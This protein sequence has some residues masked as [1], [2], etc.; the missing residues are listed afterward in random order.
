MNTENFEVNNTLKKLKS[1]ICDTK[2]NTVLMLVSIAVAILTLAV[3]FTIGPVVGYNVD[4][5]ISIPATSGS[6][7][8]S[9]TNTAI[10][11]GSEMW[12]QNTPMLAVAALIAIV[13]VIIAILMG[14]SK[15]E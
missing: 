9:T 2:A 7:W 3:I 1:L 15:S 4:S 10:T 13:G 14:V 8:N 5:A 6:G 12:S 11:N